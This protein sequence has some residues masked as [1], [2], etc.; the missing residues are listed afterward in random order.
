[1]T[2]YY[3]PSTYVPD[4]ADSSLA[5]DSQEWTAEPFV[6]LSGTPTQR[7]YSWRG[8]TNRAWIKRLSG[9][10]L[11]PSTA[12][13]G[14]DAWISSPPA[15]PASLSAQ[16]GSGWELTTT[17]GSGPTSPGSS[18]T[19][20]RDSC[21]WRTSQ[22]LFAQDLPTFSVTLP[23]SGSMRNG[24]CSPRPPLAPLTSVSGSGSWATPR[25]VNPPRSSAQRTAGPTLAEQAVG[26]DPSRP[27]DWP[28]PRASANENRTSRPAPSH[29]VTHGQ[30]LAGVASLHTPTT[31]T[32]GP[33][34]S[35][36]ADLDPQF[37]AA[38][39]G[40]PWDWLTLSTSE[41]TGSSRSAPPRHGGNSPTDLEESDAA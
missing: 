23:R 21:F 26:R 27:R 6:T 16:P 37:V 22:E 7:P 36:R 33:S 31:Q 38:L 35:P 9:L 19:W 29:G 25:A 4:T 32:D 24:V 34:G 5:C 10:T 28:T 15:S 41:E 8:W 14:V 2:W 13:R 18:A 3:V 1:M 30:T 40:L 20:N 12:Q 11:S 39:M 17:V